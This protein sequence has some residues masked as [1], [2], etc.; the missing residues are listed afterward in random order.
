MTSP[1][2]L[3]ATINMNFTPIGKDLNRQTTGMVVAYLDGDPVT[4]KLL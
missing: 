3:Y 4:G 1:N 2:S